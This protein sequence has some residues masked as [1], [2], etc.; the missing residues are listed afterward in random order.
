MLSN[1]STG[2]FYMSEN[3]VCVKTRKMFALFEMQAKSTL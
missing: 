2:P 1:N 3:V